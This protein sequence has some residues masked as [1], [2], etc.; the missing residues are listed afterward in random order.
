[1]VS[2]QIFLDGRK[3][4]TDPQRR[5]LGYSSGKWDGDTLVVDTIGFNDRGWLDAMGHPQSDA[6]HVIERFRR[7]DVGHLQIETTIDDPKAYTKPITYTLKTTLI[8]TRTLG[9]LLQRERKGR[10]ALQLIGGSMDLRRPP[11]IGRLPSPRVESERV[12]SCAHEQSES[13]LRAGPVRWTLP[14]LALSSDRPP[15]RVGL[16]PGG[17]SIIRSARALGPS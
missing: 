11:L 17:R 14:A 3:P 5:G 6:L 12:T 13:R 1:M 2:R 15:T 4:V 9:A 10:T 8:P 16:A 7:S